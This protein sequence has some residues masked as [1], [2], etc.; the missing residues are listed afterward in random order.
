MTMSA[1]QITSFHAETDHTTGF[2]GFS[3]L[4]LEAAT[5]MM[6][7][8]TAG[9]LPLPADPELAGWP[10]MLRVGS[11]TPVFDTLTLIEGG[12]ISGPVIFTGPVTLPVNTT[13]PFLP[14]AG[15]TIGDGTGAPRLNI[16]GAAGSGEG[17]VFQEAGIT[18]FSLVTTAA[19]RMLHLYGYNPD[20]SYAGQALA[21]DTDTR[22]LWTEFQFETNVYAAPIA[23]GVTGAKIGAHNTGPNATYGALVEYHSVAAD[24][25]FDTGLGVLMT[26]DPVFQPGK[27]MIF[28]AMW[29]VAISPN[30]TTHAWGGCI[31]EMNFVN[32]G[33]DPGFRRDRTFPG[34]NTGGLLFVPEVAD[35]SGGGGEGK[36][37]GYA[38]AVS[39][40][41]GTNSTGF[42][43]KTYIGFNAE[44]NS[45]VGVTGRAFYASGDITSVFS[46]IPYGPFQIEGNWLHGIDHTLAIYNDGHAVVMNAANQAFAWI[47]GTTGSPTQLATIDAF[48]IGGIPAIRMVSGPDATVYVGNGIGKRSVTLNGGAGQNNGVNWMASGTT[49]WSLVTDASDN[50]NLYAFAGTGS[51]LGTVLTVVGTEF[52]V[53]GDLRVIGK[54]GFNGVAAIAKPTVTGSR[55]GNAA[56]TSLLTALAAYGLVTDS[57]TA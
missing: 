57:T 43:A 23:G 12:L 33:P 20:G 56:V 52:Q 37:V 16:N 49:R 22:R 54:A 29:I 8:S 9:F 3:T 30:D 6:Q 10:S 15:G 51:F 45:I 36:N 44:P 39:R 1:R 2:P 19:D 28:E 24:G 46:Q 18:R 31:S 5:T 38:F 11:R 17:V 25:G 7:A 34:N 40:S 4:D 21:I 42:S 14:I 53:Q 32:R 48:P 27:Q 35:F 41:G 50:L 55:G 26:A 13:G 47:T